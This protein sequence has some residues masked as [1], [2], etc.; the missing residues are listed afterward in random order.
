[1]IT[2]A[3]IRIERAEVLHR[4]L[5]RSSTDIA[6]PASPSLDELNEGVDVRATT[7]TANNA[8]LTKIYHWDLRALCRR[9]QWLSHDANRKRPAMPQCLRVGEG[10]DRP[11]HEVWRTVGRGSRR[12]RRWPNR[13]GELVGIETNDGSSLGRG[14]AHLKGLELFSQRI[15]TLH[16]KPLLA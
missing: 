5:V 15:N 7:A 11:S 1:M 16:T 4:D 9:G 6:A 3:S 12:R 14:L 8:R 2:A 10:V 13:T